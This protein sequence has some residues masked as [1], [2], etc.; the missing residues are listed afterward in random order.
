[1]KTFTDASMHKH[2]QNYKCSIS[3]SF[4]IF[5]YILNLFTW[6]VVK[7]V[8]TFFLCKVIIQPSLIATAPWNEFLAVF[9]LHWKFNLLV[10]LFLHLLSS[11]KH[12]FITPLSPFLSGILKEVH[13]P[14]CHS[15]DTVQMHSNI[16]VLECV[17]MG[18]CVHSRQST[19]LG[20]ANCSCQCMTD[21]L[22]LHQMCLYML[23]IKVFLLNL[24]FLIPILV[25]FPWWLQLLLFS[26]MCS[27]QIYGILNSF[28]N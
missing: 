15:L 1:L 14:T 3:R 24:Y 6:S 23:M 25:C 27:D 28:L 20:N 4:L 21:I 19:P 8:I 2:T 7:P 5:C 17:L 10:L 9:H 26:F 22:F 16:H 13:L 18:A 12:C 11:F